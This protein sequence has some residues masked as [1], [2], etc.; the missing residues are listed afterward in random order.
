MPRGYRKDGTKIIP[1]S[2]KGL[3]RSRETCEKISRIHK[4]KKVSEEAKAKMRAAKLKKPTKYWL[5]KK[6]SEEDRKKMSKKRTVT[7]RYSLE[8]RKKMSERQRGEK[9]NNWKGGVET[10]NKVVRKSLEYRL[11]REAVFKRDKYTCLWC[12]RV[13]SPWDKEKKKNIPLNADHIKPFCDYPELR[14]AIENGRTLCEPCHKK[15]DTYG[16]PS[17]KNT[18]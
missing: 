3:K 2:S 12:G 7:W 17:K 15:T 10:V 16:K 4:G 9:G 6:R 18:V 13:G 14:F 8:T 5:G 11:W 1:P